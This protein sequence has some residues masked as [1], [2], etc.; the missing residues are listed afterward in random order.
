MNSRAIDQPT[1]LYPRQAREQG[2]EGTVTLHVLVS[3]TGAV[4]KVKVARG[5][6]LLTQ[7][8]V[9][10][11]GQWR[12]H[13][14]LLNGEPVEVET[15]V[16]V[17][18]NLRLG[19]ATDA[20][21]AAAKQQVAGTVLG[22]TYRNEFFGIQCTLPQEFAF[23]TSDLQARQPSETLILMFAVSEPSVHRAG[24]SIAISAEDAYESTGESWKLKTGP[25][26]LAKVERALQAQWKPSGPVIETRLGSIAFY[27][28]DFLPDSPDRAP[29][30]YLAA[31]Y[32]GHVLFFVLA[33]DGP[34][35]DLMWKSCASL[36]GP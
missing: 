24:Q 21:S 10:A 31:I 3:K 22:N 17:R 15:Q 6:P 20:S 8:A 12:Y 34:R 25:D 23:R 26:F 14:Y 1:P 27:R 18:F 2:I 36:E 13:P 7:S 11:V 16:T 4:S 9:E 33:G 28:Q 32:R 29:Q 30:R 5:H 35:Q 19:I